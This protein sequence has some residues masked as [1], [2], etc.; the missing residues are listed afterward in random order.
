MRTVVPQTV[1]APILGIVEEVSFAEASTTG[2]R[3]AV[4]GDSACAESRRHEWARHAFCKVLVN[5]LI[6]FA[7]TG[8]ISQTMIQEFEVVTSPD[9]FDDTNGDGSNRV[10]D[11]NGEQLANE[12]RPDTAECQRYFVTN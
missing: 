6:R 8:K 7:L 5:D 1:R 11:D 2:G 10:R 12:R 4:M 9:G 3:L